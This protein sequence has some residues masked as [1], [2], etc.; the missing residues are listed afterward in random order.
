MILTDTTSLSNNSRKKVLVECDSKVASGCRCKMRVSYSRILN[1]MSL[2]DSYF[3]CRVCEEYIL[4][5]SLLLTTTIY[6][7]NIDQYLDINTEKYYYLFGYLSTMV[8]ISVVDTTGMVLSLDQLHSNPVVISI[9]AELVEMRYI[10]MVVNITDKI[11]LRINPCNFL[12]KY[13]EFFN[14]PISNNKSLLS[15]FMRGYFDK[16]GIIGYEN[17]LYCKIMLGNS[18]V[19]YFTSTFTNHNI[20]NENLVYSGNNAL[21]MLAYLYENAECYV[22]Y[23]MDLYRYYCNYISNISGTGVLSFKW[24]KSDINAVCPS[25]THIS[26]SGYDLT[27]IK[28]L[29]CVGRVV[30]YDTCIKVEPNYG[31]YFDVVPRSSLSKTGYMLANSVGII[32]RTYTGNIIIAL[33]KVDLDMPDIE[34]PYRCAQMIPRQ[35]VHMKAIEVSETDIGIT[36][37]GTGGFG[38]TNK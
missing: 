32:D 36:D 2:N 38:S 11:Y 14:I 20:D 33:M 15:A 5:I 35:T 25:K 19:N 23:N 10:N 17:G 13:C 4:Y 27:V 21:D 6:D 22:Q 29:K 16:N 37:R 34:L 1:N 7:D 30:Y 26:D 8:S 9:L 3:I 31:W 12:N 28:K 18:N 24:A